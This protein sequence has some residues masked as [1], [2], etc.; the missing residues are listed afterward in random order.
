MGIRCSAGCR[1]RCEKF[2]E[3]YLDNA[4]TFHCTS[5]DHEW[6]ATLD[7]TPICDWCGEPGYILAGGEDAEAQEE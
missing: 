3:Y 6:D 7:E 5:C 4:V 1:K 2:L